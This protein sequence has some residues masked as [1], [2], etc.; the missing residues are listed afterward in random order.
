MFFPQRCRVVLFLVNMVG[1]P[2]KERM[3]STVAGHLS[4]PLTLKHD[5]LIVISPYIPIH[6]SVC[7]T[8]VPS[9]I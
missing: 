5:V 8:F 9:I 4:T 1:A 3:S 2:F 6:N 7:H